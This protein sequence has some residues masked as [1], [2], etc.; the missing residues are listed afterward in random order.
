M[1]LNYRSS[2]GVGRLPWTEAKAWV[3]HVL[4]PETCS[5][6]REKE[7][8]GVNIPQPAHGGLG[9]GPCLL[10]PSQPSVPGAPAGC[11]WLL[12]ADF[13]MGL[14]KGSS[15][16]PEAAAGGEAKVFLSL[17]SASG[18][19]AG[20]SHISRAAPS[21]HLPATSA[22][23]LEGIPAPVNTW[24]A[25]LHPGLAFRHFQGTVQGSALWLA[26]ARCPPS[27]PGMESRPLPLA[28]WMW[29][30]TLA[31]VTKAEVTCD[32]RVTS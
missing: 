3:P 7:L 17:F 1:A 10:F 21:G 31:D 23:G 19:L 27:K 15:G 22:R 6:A 28:G 5:L 18:G 20:S 8:R 4:G 16:E 13:Q 12:S 29:L 9:W 11:S 25:S 24:V 30:L 14:A 32:F 2:R 26:L